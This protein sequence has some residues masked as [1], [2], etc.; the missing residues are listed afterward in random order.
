M[1]T[2]I[3]GIGHALPPKVLTNNE[4]EKM[5]DTTEEWII[6]RTGIRERRIAD[7]NTAT[8]D[9]SYQASLMA[10]ERSGI[11]AEE[12]DL[13]IVG[14]LTPDMLLPSTACF[15]QDKL[16][17]INAAAFDVAAGC[18]GF[19]YALTTAKKFLQSPQYKYALVIGGEVLSCVT[20]YADRNTCVL[21][22]DGAGAVVLGKGSGD[23]GIINTYLGAD[24]SGAKHLYVPAGGSRMPASLQT[25]NDRMHFMRMNGNEIFRFATRITLEISN[26]LLEMAGLDYKDVDIF[27]PHQSN[28][29]I[30]KT[31][32]KR[33]KIPEE[34]TLINIRD[35]G[36]MS[37]ACIPVGLSLAEQEGRLNPGDLVLM[38]AFGG[39]LTYGGALVRWG[40]D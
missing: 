9:L 27:I 33:M 5:V 34:K 17:A 7:N 20:D 1:K 3:L 12:I 10:L 16:G 23:S 40:R 37:A 24:G 2:Q 4:L 14:T 11:S 30:I 25:V 28:L 19:V 31:A 29:R 32:M 38:V 18:T 21:F 6:E 13:I 36:N 39:G 8:S 35:F 22:G 26:K 15:V